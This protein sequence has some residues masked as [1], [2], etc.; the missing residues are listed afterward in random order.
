MRTIIHVV[1]WTAWAVCGN[2]TWADDWPCFMGPT[3]DGVSAETN[4]VTSWTESGPP[5]VWKMDVGASY[6]APS[7]VKNAL[8]LFHRLRN[9]EVLEC[10]DTATGARRWKA[11]YPTD[12][13]DRYGYNGGPRCTPLV[14]GDQVF[15]FGAAGKFCC[16]NAKTGAVVWQRNLN[17][18]LAVPQN[19]FGVGSSPLLEGKLLIVNT[20]GP[21][22]AGVVALD[23]DTGKAV[24]R[25]TDEGASYAS[26]MCATIGS[27]RFAFVF[28]RGG[29]VALDPADGKLFWRFP[30][31]SKLHESVNAASPVIAGDRVFVSASY[32]TGGALLR[33][34]KDGYD[35]VWR[36][37]VMSNHWATSILRDGYLYGFN[38]R[39]EEGTTLR[40]VELA[41]GKLMWEQAKLTRCSMI[42]ADGRFIILTEWGRLMLARLT[43]QGCEIIS[44]AQVLD[45]QRHSYIAPVLAGGFLYVRNEIQLR[46]F[47]I[48]ANRKKN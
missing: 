10:L 20:G 33:V 21:N 15:T 9:E 29:L 1:C 23:R 27:Q 30:F 12:Y 36:D 48:R 6:S 40:C 3:H 41:T 42:R 18:D 11:A 34:R 19:F 17:E 31:R 14:A 43:P 37:E 26:P 5:L 16:F 8:F 28:G 7:V 24:W 39:H 2:A 13:V 32:H 46:C 4:L 25:A 47:D 22:G 35:T 44:T 38:G 45:P